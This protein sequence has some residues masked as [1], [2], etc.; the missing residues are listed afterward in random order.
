[1]RESRIS[2]RISADN[3]VSKIGLVLSG[4]GGKGPYQL[5]AIRALTEAGVDF[6]VVAGTST[7]AINGAL[8]LACGV[9]KAEELWTQSASY[10]LFVPTFKGL[11]AALL[12]AYGL[13]SL[14]CL[15]LLS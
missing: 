14:M 13:T 10:R 12:R 11:G 5:G 7:G 8:F 4:G 15:S 6:S 1:M 3:R 9:E 2:A